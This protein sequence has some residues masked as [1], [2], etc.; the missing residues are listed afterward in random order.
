MKL[1]SKCTTLMLLPALWLTFAPACHAER[2]Y[3]WVDSDGYVQYSNRMPPEAAQHERKEINEA[4]RIVRVYSAPQTPEEK[5]EA[6][7]LAELEE[8][9]LE[10]ERKRAVHDRSLLATYSSKED[11]IDAQ[12]GKITMIESL[13]QLTHS[14][15][16]SMQDR[17]LT[18]TEEA[19][20]YERSGKPLPFALQHQLRNLRDQVENNTQFA[21]DKEQEISH[22]RKQFAQDIARYEELTSGP[23]PSARQHKSALEIALHNTKVELT[24]E[25]RTL[26]ATFSSETDLMFARNEELQKIDEEIKQAFSRVDALQKKL[27]E[28]TD[29]ADE[30]EAAGETMPDALVGQMKIVMTEIEQG[31]ALLHSKRAEKQQAESHYNTSIKRFRYLTASNP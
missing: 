19:A 4:G 30:Y 1:T 22:I 13:I 6:K 10:R 20:S 28:L 11:M 2:M 5:A 17:L 26:L 16:E 18:L 9:R 25:D 27:A 21:A 8:L 24:R 12:H 3:K 31:E 14:R 23:E 29:N 15:I 7:R